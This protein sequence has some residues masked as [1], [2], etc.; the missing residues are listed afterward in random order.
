MGIASNNARPIIIDG[1]CTTAMNAF[2]VGPFL[3]AF[4]LALGASNWEIGLISAIPFLSMPMQLVGLY[5]VNRWKRRRV[6]VVF[7]AFTARLLWI[8]IVCLP[9]FPEKASLRSL[10]TV[11]VCSGFIAAI[12]GPAWHSLVRTLIPVDALGRVFS[13]RMAWGTIVG[14][15]L[16]LAGG[17][18]VDGWPRFSGRPAL[19]AYSV[20][21]SIGIL[22]GLIG[23]RAITH[24]PDPPKESDH[25]ESFR[26]LVRLPLRD[27]GFRSLLGFVAFWNFSI[28]LAAPFFVI[29]MLERLK[30]P[31]RAVTA[32]IVLQQSVFVFSVRIWGVLSDRFSNKG[33]LVTSVPLAIMAVAAWSFTMLPERY[34]LTIPLTIAIQICI[35]FSLSAIPLSITNL[36]LKQSPQGLTHAYMM[37]TDLVGAPSGA[38]APLIGGWMMDFFA[39]HHFALTLQWSAPTRQFAVHVLSIRG[40]DFVFLIS[41]LFG[42][43]AFQWLALIQEPGAMGNIL[44]EF[45]EELSLPFRRSSSTTPFQ[46][47]SP[48]GV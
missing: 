44:W 42:L 17:F 34:A 7:C 18:F 10:L 27:A 22:F 13:K 19:E 32:L 8:V 14:L 16:T 36:A 11:L 38:I 29:F 12:P 40:L 23:V 1:I 28:N 48:L 24:L 3:A 2:F 25:S 46:E 4:A 5:A 6:L 20:L 30:L 21:F 31:M 43:I 45:K 15:V 47:N 26:R 9:F 33:V 41:A 39:A 35:G 37:M